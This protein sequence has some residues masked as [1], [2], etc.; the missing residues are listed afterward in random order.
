MLYNVDALDYLKS[1]GHYRCIFADIPDNIDYPYIGFKDI[2]VDY[3]GW[4][5]NLVTLCL[6]KSDIFWL[7]YSNIWDLPVKS[8]FWSKVNENSLF[9][10]QII[11]RYT[12]GQYNENMASGYRPI[13]LC[14]KYD[15]KLNFDAIR[16]PS[17]RQKLGDKRAAGPRVP[18]DVWDFPRVTGKNNK[19]RRDWHPTQ[20]PEQL[21]E[22]I[23][24][25]SCTEKGKNRVIGPVLDP[26]LGSG[27]TAI[28]AKRLEI[29]WDGFEISPF[30]CKMLEGILK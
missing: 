2:K 16:V 18:D 7:S 29:P 30:Y 10:R 15:T 11:W 19:E 1:C 22:R 8:L 21:L 4:I 17:A 23:L 9:V 27:T 20:H 3:I 28:V 13:I 6:Q 25:L 26:F 24:K 5:R 12:F 14:Y